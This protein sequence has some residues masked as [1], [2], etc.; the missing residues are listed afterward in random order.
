MIYSWIEFD[1]TMYL[2]QNAL[3]G[4]YQLMTLAQEVYGSEPVHAI[5][6]N[7]WR[8]AENQTCA[9]YAAEVLLK[10]AIAPEN[11]YREYAASFGIASLENYARVMALIDDADTAARDKLPNI[12]FCYAGCW[13]VTGLG[14]YGVFKPE[15]LDEVRDMYKAAQDDLTALQSDSPYLQFIIN[16]LHCT[17]TYLNGV[18]IAVALQDVCGDKRPEQLDDLE[19]EIVRSICDKALLY[20]EAMMEYH[21][22]YIADRGCEGT[23]ISFYYTP[24]AVL[25]RIRAEYGGEGNF[26]A[27]SAS[28]APPA[29]IWSEE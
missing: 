20:M 11:F 21:A 4:I 15:R 9:R 28:D 5:S 1:G 29:P 27:S 6:L 14:Y 16:R 23:L 18:K 13:G 19:Q 25:K 22:G 10:G 24:P 8:T 3:T 26:T 2:F 17:V 12:G 7:H